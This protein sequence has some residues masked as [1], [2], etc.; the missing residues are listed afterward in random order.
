MSSSIVK[1]GAEATITWGEWHGR[2]V[3]VKE[4][5]PKA[6]RDPSLDKHLRTTR[7]RREAGLMAEA[8]KY[9]VRTPVVFDIDIVNSIIIMEHVEGELAKDVIQSSEDRNEI[10]RLIGRSVGLLHL[11]G[12]VHGDLT[13]SNMIIQAGNVNLIDFGLGERSHEPEKKGVDLH[14]LKEALD[15]AHSQFP[16]LFD[17]VSQGYLEVYGEGEKILTIVTDIEKRG[18]YS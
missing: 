5:S 7:T 15:S 17:H 3:V 2:Q 9:G 1:R 4:R 13:T 6:Y 8:R 10:A 18:R 12:L 14:L 16:E 11:N